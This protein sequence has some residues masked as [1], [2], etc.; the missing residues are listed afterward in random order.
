MHELNSK[1]WDDALVLARLELIAIA[2]GEEIMRCFEAPAESTLKHDASPVT[3]A[4]RVAEA[5]ILQALAVSFPGV[6]CVAEEAASA[7]DL[8]ASLGSV[9]FLV[10]PLDG[11]REFI[12]RRDDFTVNIALVRDGVPVVGVV[13]APAKGRLYAGRPRNAELVRFDN[14]YEQRIRIEVR[15]CEDAPVIAVSRSHLTTATSDFI[16]R[17]P[18]ATTTAIGSSLKFCLMAAG[19]ADLYPRFGRT[20]EW[21]TAA[22]DAVL[23]AAGGSVLTL[24]GKPLRYGKRNQPTDTDFANPWFMAVTGDA[25]VHAIRPRD[26]LIQPS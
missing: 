12:E 4:D 21:D 18:G 1:A 2:A 19:D 14:G 17:I 22:G 10:D 9:F 7:G 24:D 13:H 6:P 3:E 25:W 23:R 20:M 15:R 11:T 8:P 16:A 5:L 26:P